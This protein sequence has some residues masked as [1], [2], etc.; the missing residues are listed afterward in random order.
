MN[1]I[2][3]VIVDHI[4]CRVFLQIGQSRPPFCF[5]FVLFTLQFKKKLKKQR[6]FAWDLNPWP[7]DGWSRWIHWAMAAQN[8]AADYC[9]SCSYLTIQLIFSLMSTYETPT[10]LWFLFR[11]VLLLA[12]SIRDLPLTSRQTRFPWSCL[13]CPEATRSSLPY[14]KLA[15]TSDRTS[16]RFKWSGWSS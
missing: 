10:P 14:S 16:W 4:C 1:I 11:R 9:T 5:I 8:I 12:E 15:M 2:F 6:C 3:T 13:S 7:K